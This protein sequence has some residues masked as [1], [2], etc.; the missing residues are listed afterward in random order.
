MTV[1]AR[2]RGRI[3]IEPLAAAVLWGG[4][5]TAVKLAL[6]DIP[7]LSL[8][9][10]RIV[11]A[12]LLLFAVSGGVGW[13]GQGRELWRPLIS[14]GLAQTTFQVLVMQG[15]SRTTASISAILLASAPLITA[16][17]LAATRRER[18]TARQWG[19]LVLGIGGVAVLMGPDGSDWAG[20]LGGNVVALGSAV[21]WAWYS[22]AIGPLAR[23]VGPVRATAGTLAV[24][25]LVL[26]PFGAVEGSTVS[27][28]GV[29]AVAWAG[30]LYGAVLGLALATILWVRSIQRWGTQATMNY[31]YVEP[32][33]AVLIAALVLGETLRP[34]QGLG[35]AM[36]LLGVYLASRVTTD[37]HR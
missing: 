9:A 11:L 24:A 1:P 5:F 22:L 18:L 25:A 16:G 23:A 36:A 15:L 30:L 14:A 35:A 4:V 12:V 8:T 26:A 32:V 21:A 29:S 28:S 33:A 3:L 20:S 7:V 19:G 10:G 13:L 6:V 31:G 17:W 2:L 34:V 27:W 37:E